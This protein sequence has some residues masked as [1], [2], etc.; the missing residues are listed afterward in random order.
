MHR[1]TDLVW[2]KAEKIQAEYQEETVLKHKVTQM[3]ALATAKHSFDL[4][5]RLPGC[6]LQKQGLK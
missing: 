6:S 5:I 3:N 2:R 1:T 4:L